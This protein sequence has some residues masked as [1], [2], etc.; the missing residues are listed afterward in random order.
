M[1]T[2]KYE[3]NIPKF[4]SFYTFPSMERSVAEGEGVYIDNLVF[5]IYL[6]IVMLS[7]I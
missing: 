2:Q 4:R 5:P 3:L 1:Y 6:L 7:C